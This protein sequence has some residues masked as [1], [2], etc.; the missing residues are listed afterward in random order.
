MTVPLQITLLNWFL[1]NLKC[2]WFLYYLKPLKISVWIEERKVNATYKK[3]LFTPKIFL[4]DIIKI[5][6]MAMVYIIAFVIRCVWYLSQFICLQSNIFLKIPVCCALGCR[7]N[8]KNG[9]KVKV[10]SFPKNDSLKSQWLKALNRKDFISTKCSRV[11][12]FTFN[13]EK[14]LRLDIYIEFISALWTKTV[15]I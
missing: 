5:V 9:P 8:Y 13:S 15:P 1:T 7:G 14:F 12:S 2:K 11:S 4:R 3:S 10:F 6:W